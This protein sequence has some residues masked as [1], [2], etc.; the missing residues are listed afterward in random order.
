VT[1][2]TPV[3]KE[4]KSELST[5]SKRLACLPADL[6]GQ[7]FELTIAKIR[8]RADRLPIPVGLERL[9]IG[10]L[11]IFDLGFFNF[12]WFDAFTDSGKF[13]VTRLRQKTAYQV[14]RTLL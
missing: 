14:I 3:T 10:G 6:F 5:V 13:F 4:L 8:A 9:L 12:V 11:L 1:S 2:T 7:V